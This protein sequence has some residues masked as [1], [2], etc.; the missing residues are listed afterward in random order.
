[1][2]TN[3]G[4]QL[5]P[6]E[7]VGRDREIESLWSHLDR[8]SVVITAERRMGKTSLVKKMI[9][10]SPEQIECIYQELEGIRSPLKFVEAIIHEISTDLSWQQQTKGKW[11]K[12]H[13][14]MSEAKLMGVTVPKATETDWQKQLTSVMADLS[15]QLAKL[16]PDLLFIFFWDELPIAIDNIRQDCG[17]NAAMAVLDT[18]R[19]IRQTHSNLRMVYTGSVGLHHIVSML[20]TNGY[21][22]T[23]TNDMYAFDLPPLA[24]VDAVNLAREL[25][26]GEGLLTD[27]REI[28]AQTIA[29]AVDYIP[30][31]IHASIDRLKREPAPISSETV[32][33]TI[34]HSLSAADP[35]HIDHYQ[36]RIR[37]YY[38][39]SRWR[40]ALQTLDEIAL[41]DSAL[42]FKDI[43]DRVQMQIQPF[44]RELQREI[45]TLLQQDHYLDRDDTG[46]YR[47][48]FKLIQQYWQSQRG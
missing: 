32:L 46:A 5:A 20:K 14:A 6:N 26:L 1:M 40:I 12:F 10:E 11:Q 36:T 39:E 45:L 25:S 34:R 29:T 16:A 21:H 2:R 41:A 19:A 27:D 4:G 47:F 15:A 48:R 33:S 30:F 43:C 3:P 13:Q 7:V 31:Y 17:N 23:P 24:E 28:V 37:G 18:L 35:W 42:T 38:G 44:D 8:Q 22:G 9:A